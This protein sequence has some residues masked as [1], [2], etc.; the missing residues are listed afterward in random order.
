MDQVGMA[1]DVWPALWGPVGDREGRRRRSHRVCRGPYWCWG[2]WGVTCAVCHVQGRLEMLGAVV[3]AGRGVLPSKGLFGLNS[4]H[5]LSVTSCFLWNQEQ[6]PTP[7]EGSMVAL[8]Y[9]GF[10]P[11][12][13]F[14]NCKFPQNTIFLPFPQSSDVNWGHFS[15]WFQLLWARKKVQRIWQFCGGISVGWTTCWSFPVLSS[16]FSSACWIGSSCL[17]SGI[18]CFNWSEIGFRC[19]TCDLFR[20]WLDWSF[21]TQ[22]LPF[23]QNNGFTSTDS[24]SK[25]Y[26][27]WRNYTEIVKASFGQKGKSSQQI[28]MILDWKW[29]GW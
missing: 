17:C 14:G 29:D 11:E 28:G 9:D 2:H 25:K 21:L 22:F 20:F 8:P 5:G 6:M 13:P 1:R 7:G 12:C 19:P 24:T 3:F 16:T 26:A 15:V 10:L 4:V 23:G 18:L 27:D